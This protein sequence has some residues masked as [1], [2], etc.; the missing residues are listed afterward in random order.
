MPARVEIIDVPSFTFVLIVSLLLAGCSS[1][2]ADSTASASPAIATA[3]E[4]LS[5]V[6]GSKRPGFLGAF[7]RPIGP[8]PFGVFSVY[9][10]QRAPEPYPTPTTH[11]FGAGGYCDAVASNGVS[12]STGYEVDSRK[13]ADI[14]GLNV[15]WT[16]TP[17]SADYDDQSH[18]F[19]PGR[20]SFGDFDSAQ[21]ALARKHIVPIV[22]LEA[23]TVQYNVDPEQFSPKEMEIYKSAQDF[24]E[25]CGVVATHETKTFAAVTRYSLPGNEVNSNAKMFQGGDRQIA[26]YS[27]ACYKAIKRVQPRS[28]IYGFEL[29]MDKGLDAPG[30]VQRM[31]DLGCKKGTCYDA[32]S[33]HLFLPYPIPLANTPCYPH[34]GGAY[35]M[36]CIADVQKATHT[37]EMHIL[38]GETAFMVPSTVPDETTKA[39]AIV[40]ALNRFATDRLVDGVNYANVDECDLYPSGF[41]MGGCLVDSLGK[42]LAG[43]DA[44]EALATRAF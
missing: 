16:R 34:P 13:L 40:E 9:S 41:F 4:S 17:V 28:V 42:K 27:E 18:I 8:T 24:G 19:G 21:C 6:S 23:G 20:Y 5:N 15:K 22:G 37:A 35:S 10:K 43:Y 33:I 2:P 38:I 11:L 1:T 12:I 32:L 25:W 39:K 44:L 29:N 14:V 7:F 31:Y 3:Q 36:K 26:G 30:F